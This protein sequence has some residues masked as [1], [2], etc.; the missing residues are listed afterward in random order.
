MC[1]EDRNVSL[2]AGKICSVARYGR[3]IP[4]EKVA[5]TP[6]QEELLS[7]YEKNIK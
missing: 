1:S 6:E 5:V 3:F 7:P 2:C 4:G